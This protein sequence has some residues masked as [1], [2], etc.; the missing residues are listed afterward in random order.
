[1]NNGSLP[2]MPQEFKSKGPLGD[3]MT[4]NFKGL[5]KREYMA[6]MAMQGLCANRHGHECSPDNISEFAVSCA[7]SLLKELEK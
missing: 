5:T 6:A 1:M 2:A 3:T 7:D 4:S